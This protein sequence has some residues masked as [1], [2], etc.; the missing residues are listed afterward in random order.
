MAK[1]GVFFI[2]ILM[3]F[4]KDLKNTKNCGFMLLCGVFTKNSS[5][6]YLSLR[7]FLKINIYQT[8]Q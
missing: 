2:K 6:N 3:C 5:I 1:I 4:K 7:L 8:N